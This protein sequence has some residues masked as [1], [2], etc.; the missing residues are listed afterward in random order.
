MYMFKLCLGIHK[1]TIY[2]VRGAAGLLDTTHCYPFL[3]P[4]KSAKNPP[5][6]K[7]AKEGELN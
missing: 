5:K 4:K 2:K 1:L 3:N 6:G 7:A